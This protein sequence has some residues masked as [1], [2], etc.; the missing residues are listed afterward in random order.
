MKR[1]LQRAVG[2]VT[3]TPRHLRPLKPAQGP[4]HLE[5]LEP[6]MLLSGVIGEIDSIN[7]TQA[8]S[9]D[10][11]VIQ[12]DR[13][14]TKPV[15]VVG[16]VQSQGADPTTTRVRNVT[17]SSF[18][19]QVDEWDY[20]DGGHIEET[21]AYAV[22]E[23]GRHRL[24]DGTL[25]EAGNLTGVGAPGW[26][27]GSFTSGFSTP[28]VLLGGVTTRAEADAVAP[29]F[30]NISSSGF[31]AL[32]QEQ[33]LNTQSH[34][35]ET[36]SYL[37]IQSGSGAGWKSGLLSN[38]THANKNLP[39]SGV[40]SSPPPL[41]ANIQTY[42]GLDPSAL[43]HNA[44]VNNG[45]LSAWVKVEEEKSKDS[46]TQHGNETVGYLAHEVGDL[47]GESYVGGAWVDGK[48]GPHRPTDVTAKAEG[49]TLRVTWKDHS[50]SENGYLVETSTDGGST[51]MT[52]AQVA[53]D[54][55]GVTLTDQPLG[56]SVDARVSALG[57]D[58]LPDG[59]AAMAAAP[60][61]IGDE[62]TSGVYEVTLHGM[63][64]GSATFVKLPNPADSDKLTP[65]GESVVVYAG[66]WKHAVELAVSGTAELDINFGPLEPETQTYV[67]GPAGDKN[68]DYVNQGFDIRTTA[69]AGLRWATDYE[70]VIILEDLLLVDGRSDSP[71]YN[72]DDDYNDWFWGLN[73]ERVEAV[74]LDIDSDNNS[75]TGP[76][77]TPEEDALEELGV[78][79]LL[80]ANH[81]DRDG[82]GMFDLAD[83]YVENAGVD[84]ALF[85]QHLVPMELDLEAV[86]EVS[87]PGSFFVRF[88]YDASDPLAVTAADASESSMEL[89]GG[90]LRVWR[91][92]S[93]ADS[94]SGASIL[95]GGDF[96]PTGE[97]IPL[98]ELLSQ[99]EYGEYE[100][101]KVYL[102]IEAVGASPIPLEE[103]V[104]VELLATPAEECEDGYDDG[105]S[106]DDEYPSEGSSS[107]DESSGESCGEGSA[108]GTGSSS[109]EEAEP[110]VIGEDTITVTAIEPAAP[111]YGGPS[112][113]GV[114]EGA[115]GGNPM[116]DSYLGPLRLDGQVQSTTAQDLASTGLGWFWGQT[117]QWT[118][119]PIA[120]LGALAGT[121]N[122][123][124]QLPFL[125]QGTSTILGVFGAETT[126]Y[127]DR[128]KHGE[129]AD[130]N[131]TTA[132]DTRFFGHETIKGNNTD[133]YTVKDSAGN[134]FT[135]H[136]FA[137]SIKPHQR[138]RLDA[139][140]SPGGV[141]AQTLYDAKG[142]IQKVTINFTDDNGNT[143]TETWDYVFNA[144]EGGA[145]PQSSMPEVPKLKSLVYQRDNQTVSSARYSY[146]AETLEMARIYEGALPSED[147]WGEVGEP[148]DVEEKVS[149][150]YYYRTTEDKHLS[151]GRAQYER[152]ITNEEAGLLSASDSD[153]VD[154]GAIE[155]SKD[156]FRAPGLGAA[157]NN[158]EAGTGGRQVV[159]SDDYEDP[160]RIGANVWRYKIDVK[161]IQGDGSPVQQDRFTTY[162]LNSARQVM[163]KTVVA[164]SKH[165][166]NF[167]EH[168]EDGRITLQASPS[169][170]NGPD[171]E[172]S[173]LLKKTGS[174]G[175]SSQYLH[176]HDDQGVLTRFS[177][178]E[179]TN[180]FSGYL[181]EVT[182]LRGDTSATLEKQAKYEYIEKGVPRV[183]WH[184]IFRNGTDTEDNKI[185]TQFIYDSLVSNLPKQVEVV[186]PTVK[187]EHG[188]S[189]LTVKAT[190]ITD[191]LGRVTEVVDADGY[192]STSEY[193]DVFGQEVHETADAGGLALLTKMR[194]DLQGRPVEVTDAKG[195]VT[196]FSYLNDWEDA[197]SLM[198][199][200]EG[201][202][203]VTHFDY[204]IG[205]LR[206][207]S[208]S[209]DTELGDDMGEW[210][211]LHG[212]V[213]EAQDLGG[214][215]IEI[216]RHAAE[217]EYTTTNSF[218]EVG[219]LSRM[220][221]AV[222]T[223][224]E[225]QF[226]DLDRVTQ[227]LV[228]G[229]IVKKIDYDF[230]A[231]GDGLVSQVTLLPG[232]VEADRVTKYYSD[233]RGRTVYTHTAPGST[234]SRLHKTTYD[235]LGRA[236]QESVLDAGA[237]TQIDRVLEQG[238]SNGAPAVGGDDV[239]ETVLTTTQGWD[240]RG[241]L[242]SIQLTDEGESTTRT[243]AF[244]RDNRGN[245]VEEVSPTGAVTKYAYNGVGWLQSSRVGDGDHWAQIMTLAYDKAGNVELITTQDLTAVAENAEDD[246]YRSSYVG[247]WFDKMDRL[248][249]TA[250][251][252][253]RASA[254]NIMTP[255]SGVRPDLPDRSNQILVTSNRYDEHG[256]L[257]LIIDP[258]GIATALAYD[259]L[260]RVTH[261]V[262]NAT[263]GITTPPGAD[264]R[265]TR[266]KY[267]GVDRTIQTVQ[268]LQEDD[269]S[270]QS[271]ADDYQIDY[272]YDEANRK[273]R[274]IYGGEDPDSL[275]PWMFADTIHNRIGEVVKHRS[276]DQIVHEY[277][278]DALGRVTLDK[279]SLDL[280]SNTDFADAI[281][282]G[283]MSVKYEYDALNHAIRVTKYSNAEATSQI[284]TVRRTYNAFGQLR[285]EEQSHDSNNSGRLFTY[286]Y[287]E[288]GRPT[289]IDYPGDYAVTYSYDNALDQALGRVTSISET[290]G[291]N[292]TTL[293]SYDYEGIDFPARVSTVSAYED[294]VDLHQTRDSF[295]RLHRQKWTEEL[296]PLRELTTW[297][298]LGSQVLTVENGA[299]PELS[300]LW[301]TTPLASDH[302]PSALY[303]P[304]G[305]SS[306]WGY[307]T[308]EDPS[309]PGVRPFRFSNQT[310]KV[311]YLT[312]D[313]SVHSRIFRE[314]DQNGN[315]LGA[316]SQHHHRPVFQGD[317]NTETLNNHLG[318][319]RAHSNVE[320]D[321][322]ASV[323][324]DP[325]GQ[326]KSRE[327]WNIE[328]DGGN[329]TVD[330]DGWR[331]YEH[332]G[333]GRLIA[334]RW[335]QAEP[336]DQ[337]DASVTLR[338]FYNDP[339]GRMLEQWTKAGQD[340][341]YDTHARY[342]WSPVTGRLILRDRD[343]GGV[344]D[345]DE[346]TWAF[347]DAMGN[348]AWLRVR[349]SG[350]FLEHHDFV[351][352]PEGIVENGWDDT[353]L[354]WR[355]G[356]RSAWRDF[357]HLWLLPDG[358]M[359]D[360]IQASVIAPN[361]ES[362]QQ[363]TSYEPPEV[364]WWQTARDVASWIPG[365]SERVWLGQQVSS[366]MSWL[367][368]QS[369]S[370]GDWLIEQGVPWFVVPAPY[371]QA[372]LFDM[373]GGIVSAV[374]DPISA[375]EGVAHNVHGV[376]NRYGTAAAIGYTAFLWG[377]TG[378]VEGLA[379]TNFATGE[380]IGDWYARGGQIAMGISGTAGG[381]AG[382]AKM[383][384]L[385]PR[386]SGSSPRAT[387]APVDY[388]VGRRGGETYGRARLA[389][390]QSYMQ[391]R[392]VEVRLGRE[393]SFDAKTPS[394]KP[395][396]TLKK[397]PTKYEVWHEL[398]HY[399]QYKKLGRDNYLAQPRPV[400]PEQYVFDN[401]MIPRR[402]SLLNELERGDAF[403]YIKKSGGDPYRQRY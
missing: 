92:P 68:I 26:T 261:Q 346:R 56:A 30:R 273:L 290:T 310:E 375:A 301:H 35:S 378:V 246:G 288:D 216:T 90:L 110:Q 313:Q 143:G 272:V 386:I 351:Y 148:A 343:P 180:V 356:F 262:Q 362:H 250:E 390:L 6:R 365:D 333:L 391:R 139:Y 144:L 72:N 29:R 164:N 230:G 181:N 47:L 314:T 95:E 91:E 331:E 291:G 372:T 397:N 381:V 146:D 22:V 384:G 233:W 283:T 352:S 357:D 319:W 334:R 84:P 200:P 387:S 282:D 237:L 142:L 104:K 171:D 94:R 12:M 377:P 294:P 342:V 197:A 5:Q 279:T 184:T 239:P 108:D 119:D 285:E 203:E 145:T 204:G 69:E 189:G 318:A 147:S 80:V 260:G 295:G 60:A 161:R 221:D 335:A 98:E 149:D 325:W 306:Q 368:D 345:L 93:D 155:V 135:F 303:D 229:V 169:S 20:L 281:F 150:T 264:T 311:E 215:T 36:L 304:L 307:G 206:T 240:D 159:E 299:K 77:G 100:A 330:A 199:P 395:Q 267:D 193:K 317:Y 360:S 34:A 128:V 231:V 344:A 134:T 170:I 113:L 117:R 207:G 82:N 358:G 259:E 40:F 167:Y 64:E 238:G 266:Y 253:V 182:L 309:Q 157:T 363:L 214:R 54:A 53:A 76:D 383:A 23:A 209:R 79:K 165:Y 136:G 73:V 328:Y 81:A 118:S 354:D 154:Y 116:A 9:N 121:G 185:R 255:A 186:L 39:L 37:A 17:S 247:Q 305:R 234:E 217:A 278:R 349:L 125:L 61:E 257:D 232:G 187:L 28:P 13:E 367:A 74:D 188:G 235:N 191:A 141:V 213:A 178:Y 403:D 4:R 19:L 123:I 394:G 256:Y 284:S 48:G 364:S 347:S 122:I 190:V 103:K 62:N 66:S 226:D 385:N 300:Q 340:E 308:L 78:G 65:K 107:G 211:D 192:R 348:V 51:W 137:E 326:V 70:H 312:N 287:D 105:D 400:G 236:L 329:T 152:L 227:E 388:H 380:A 276:K 18:E 75:D 71:L 243:T 163:L 7:L 396:I 286:G 175:G 332:D 11:T 208:V 220:V 371:V 399:R 222:G 166:S 373:G 102:L 140:T 45:T 27:S 177:Y 55:E 138:G 242:Y 258:R 10:W 59:A 244:K 241:R 321:V 158:S 111:L 168:D 366:G 350:G 133:G 151:L 270:E 355:I 370:G 57:A 162:Y 15:V 353:D 179:A 67:F 115:D 52:A 49:S 3:P 33:E 196:S 263:S 153:L 338:S 89:P 124:A 126:V 401:L 212:L 275:Q 337:G 127:F 176:I 88:T 327:N 265:V 96:I 14:Y 376:Y 8:G 280:G 251:Y 58:G 389:K 271:D 46:E 85:D 174:A 198:L 292:T 225:A 223:V 16:P 44:A 382:A 374:T 131:D 402:W 323:R 379:D 160:K 183:E 361:A 173:D 99:D 252:G 129:H 2:L 24:A 210:R 63:Q 1:L 201:P 228:Q 277:E 83:G 369:R 269:P 393:N 86:T 296:L 316:A 298:D 392:G 41:L 320:P 218:N 112:L 38:V 194:N 359:W 249:G 156:Q 114:G 132:Y 97:L 322:A 224:Y 248:V 289:G 43:R 25:L 339:A 120:G 205:T 254:P 336:D 315:P 245:T 42:S 50:G 130:D 31:E 398:L 268:E 172:E 21:I 101:T 106:G 324:F 87:N 341:V 219:L 297:Y 274:V 195:R 302:D 202:A 109:S 293:E 32:L